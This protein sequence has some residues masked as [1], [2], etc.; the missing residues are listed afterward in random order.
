M[1]GCYNKRRRAGAGSESIGGRVRD[2]K[3]RGSWE[4]CSTSPSGLQCSEPRRSVARTVEARRRLCCDARLSRFGKPNVIL[5]FQRRRVSCGPL[6]PPAPCETAAPVW[7]KRSPESKPAAA[8]ISVRRNCGWFSTLGAKRSWSLQCRPATAVA[9]ISTSQWPLT[10]V[11]VPKPTGFSEAGYLDYG[12]N[13]FL[14]KVSLLP[15][16]ETLGLS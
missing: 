1:R 2:E 4:A 6:T 12:G 7:P 8:E 16:A 15:T 5:P 3:G 14:K 13:N 11:S 10:S 9:R